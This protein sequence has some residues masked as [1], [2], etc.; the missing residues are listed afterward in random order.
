[1]SSVILEQPWDFASLNTLAIE[2]LAGKSGV[3]DIIARFL[4][5]RGISTPEAVAQH[6]S[7]ALKS[8]SDPWKMMDMD[9][10][11]DRLVKAVAQREQVAVF[12]DYDVDGVTSA[13]LVSGFL[14]GLGL[15]VTVYIPHRENEGYG[16]SAEGLRNLASRGYKLLITVD[17]GISD[18][19]EVALAGE[20]GMDVII[21]DHH[22]PPDSLPRALAVLNPKRSDCA[23]AFKEL[24]GVGVAFNLV[25]ALRHRLY[26]LGHWNTDQVP[27]LK[28]YL[29]FV[30]LGTV[31]DVVPLLGDNRILV[32][33]GLEVLDGSDR[34]GIKALKALCSLD[35]GITSTDIAFRIAPRLNAAGRMAHADK[36]FRLLVTDDESEAKQLADELHLLN[37]ERQAEEKNIFNQAL[38]KIRLL[39]KQPAYVLSSPEW[40]RGIIG[41]VASRLV[42]Q[43]HRPVILLALDGDEAHGSGRSPEGI[44]L[45]ESL[46]A[47]SGHLSSFGGHRAAAGMRL[48]SDSVEGFCTAFQE[49]VASVLEQNDICPRLMVD[50][51]ACIEELID[52][53]FSRFYE[54]LEPFGAGYPAPLFAVRDFSV[55]RSTVVGNGHLKLSL[56]SRTGLKNEYMRGKV[57]LVGWGHG[58]KVGLP[59]EELELACMPCINVWQGRKQLELRLKDIRYR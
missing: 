26:E 57:D 25:R 36:A 48:P 14:K 17:C 34:P 5:Q 54:H 13:A 53:G 49:V 22:E 10:A 20:L 58:D 6:L 44:N 16:L 15:K 28:E 56:T 47:C 59:W 40:K 45:Y 52:P 1:M 38:D 8:L 35:S 33:A 42:Q 32:R 24:A 2:E 12:G 30:A 51:T 27:N 43:F 39:E 4:Y 7:P 21:T 18:S 11:V 9:K 23:F 46:C 37:Q 55:R 19:E 41:I 29:D 50:C 3:P 31:A